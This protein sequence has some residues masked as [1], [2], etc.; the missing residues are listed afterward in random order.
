VS[1][2]TV[3]FTA[4]AT[5]AS[6][7]F[8][9]ATTATAVTNASG[10]AASPIPVANGVVG[11]YSVSATATGL[12][13]IEFSLTNTAPPVPATATF[14]KA[15]SATQ[16]N[17]QLVYGADGYNVI[18]DQAS[19]PGY[20]TP[21]PSGQLSF[22]WAATTTDVRALRKASNPASR[23]AGTWFS[24]SSFTVDMNLIDGAKHQV[25]LYFVDWDSAARRQTIEVLDTSGNVLDTEVLGW[26]FNGGVYLVWNVS[27]HVQFQFTLTAGANA[28]LSGLF[29]DAAASTQTITGTAGTPQSTTVD[30]AFATALEATVTDKSGN[31]VSGATV[32]FSSPATG[33]GATFGGGAAMSATAISNAAGIAISPLPAANTVAGTYTVTASVA[34]VAVPAFTLTNA[35]GPAA[36]LTATAGTVQSTA[37]S[38]A[39][40]IALQAMVKD[41]FGNPVSGVTVT[42]AAPAAGASANF[43]GSQSQLVLTDATGTAVSTVPVANGVA[44]AYSISATVAG[45]TPVTFGLTNT[46]TQLPATATFVKTDWATQG[47]WQAVYGA[48]GYNVIGDQ[49]SNP[50]YVTPLPSGQLSYVWSASTS[51][52]RALQKASNP[53]SRIAGTWFSGSSFTID[54]NLVDGATHQVGIYCLDW[55]GT[56]RR[57]TITVMD[58]A[59]NVLDTEVLGSSF[60]GGVYLVWNVSGHVQFQFTLTAGANAAVSGLFFDA[61]ASAQT[62]RLR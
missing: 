18:G 56:A 4:P 9:G 1:G 62:S 30:T 53:A 32:T 8:G 50:G 44:G 11:A 45:L 37:V 7:T 42:F 21:L 39:F 24:G 5:G 23:I 26:S 49:V 46:A 58:T 31:P 22:L 17:W 10:V 55:D 52:V 34:G 13:T 2:V 3:T 28:V 25:A 61:A 59:G 27:G 33:A 43:A 35:A 57:Q 54:M 47:N 60:N 20:V 12:R 29:F 48:D 40:P 51:D 36:S 14:V 6:A 41:G 38:T 19:N 15:D 16:G